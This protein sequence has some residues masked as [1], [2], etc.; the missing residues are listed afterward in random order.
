MK[1]LK[2]VCFL[3]FVCLGDSLKATNFYIN[4][5]AGKD[6]NKGTS[7]NDCWKSILPIATIQL[8]PGDSILFAAGQ[9]FTGMLPLKNVKG[10][11]QH[12]VVI[13]S[14]PYL[15][16]KAKP[17]LDAGKDLNALFIQ[18]SSFIHVTGIEFT[19]IVP[20]QRPDPLN[21]AEMRCGILVEV[22]KDEAYQHIELTDVFVH[23]VYY[24]P[25]GYTRS[26]SEIKSANGTQSYGWGI[27]FINNSKAGR[28]T[29]VKVL[30]SEI[31]NVSH[32]GLK[33]TATAGGIQQLEVA[34]CKIYQTGGPGIQFSGI[35]EGHIHH[36]TIDH[37]GSTSDTRNWGRGSGLWTWSCN[38]I[39]I[40]H[41]RFEN[42]NGPGDS[43]GVHIDYNCSDVVIQYNLSANNAGGFCEILG[44]NNNCAYRYNISIN[45]GNRVKGTN[46]AFQEGKIFWLSGY[47]GNEKRN[48]GPYNSY[49]Y[50]NTIY[51]SAN[52]I[53]KIAVS[54]STDG[55]LIANN[56]F[57]FEGFAQMVPGDQKKQEL[58]HDGVPN[59]VFTNNLFLRPD[60][61]PPGFPLQDS[62]PI[63]GDPL[64]QNKGGLQLENYLPGSRKLIINKGVS[65]LPI[66]NDKIGLRIGLKV[67]RDILGNSIKG[68]PDLG[69]IELKE[70]E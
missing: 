67:E 51:V 32:T 40:E 18:N 20:Y 19:G 11:M 43:A 60:N 24:H 35:V 7:P 36:N 5:A 9:K 6:S 10:L 21:N 69:A 47:Q 50:N 12:P 17:I 55:V 3:W 46:G 66:P 22:T 1:L 28:L 8:K 30:K 29:G 37:S 23:D 59:V 14:Y 26:A 45:D 31:F 44:N 68:K 58:D 57:C 70:I 62:A 4:V 63:I 65:I 13:G 42:A 15:S 34:D 53:P 61:W 41:N 2:I 48:A 54:S 38:N 49:F 33:V 56:I 64:F 39:L 16:K 25:P 27:R 52:I